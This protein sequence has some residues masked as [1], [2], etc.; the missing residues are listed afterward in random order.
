MI[1]CPLSPP[2]T[3]AQGEGFKTCCPDTSMHRL[4][5]TTFGSSV[6]SAV[7]AHIFTLGMMCEAIGEPDY[8]GPEVQWLGCRGA[9]LW[10][11]ELSQRGEADRHVSF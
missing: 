7:G 5:P 1:T 11:L 9:V 6:G 3:Q 4:S 8:V 10:R 2:G